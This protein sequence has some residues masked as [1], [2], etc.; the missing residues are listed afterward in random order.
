MSPLFQHD[1]KGL[2]AY[3]TISHLGLIT[4]LMGLGSPLAVVA[5]I[6]HILNHATFKASLFMA[7]G[8]IDHETGTRDI[9]RLQGLRR[10]M[11]ITATLAIVASAAMAG[12]PLLNGFLSKEMFFAETVLAGCCAASGGCS[13]LPLV[14]TLAGMFSV[15]YRCAL[16]YVFFAQRRLILPPQPARAGALDAGAGGAAGADLPGGR[17]SAPAVSRGPI[18]LACGHARWSAGCPEYSLAIWHGINLPLLMSADCLAGR[19]ALSFWQLPLCAA[20]VLERTP[21][22]H[23]FRR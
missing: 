2:L 1:L 14:V 10:K 20:P 6:F 23:R 15:A 17:H 11:P 16:G 5:A 9:Q 19:H 22:M 4:V 3:S 8:I 12:V 13:L 18:L 21:L 7:A